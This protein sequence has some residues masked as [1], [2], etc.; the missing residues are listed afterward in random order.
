[1]LRYVLF[2]RRRMQQGCFG[3]WMAAAKCAR[4]SSTAFGE[5]SFILYSAIIN[6]FNHD[7]FHKTKG[8]FYQERRSALGCVAF[9]SNSSLRRS[10]ASRLKPSPLRSTSLWAPRLTEGGLNIPQEHLERFLDG[11]HIITFIHLDPLVHAR[12]CTEVITSSF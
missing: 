8:S 10:R 6:I 2:A 7:S 1:M 11:L 12:P 4:A 3:G 5:P 9:L